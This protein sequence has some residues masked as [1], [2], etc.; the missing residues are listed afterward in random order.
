MKHSSRAYAVAVI[1]GIGVLVLL[2]SGCSREAQTAAVVTLPASA[3]PAHVVKAAFRLWSDGNGAAAVRYL[4]KP[5][6]LGTP[7]D[8]CS[9]WKGDALVSVSNPRMTAPT[10]FPQYSVL[11]S[12]CEVPVTIRTTKRDAETG[13]PPGDYTYFVLMGRA[14]QKSRWLILEIGTGP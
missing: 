5:S 12:V 13:E 14:S 11:W 7:S 6:R 10:E 1:V 8:Y 2:S 3:S 9:D 4:W